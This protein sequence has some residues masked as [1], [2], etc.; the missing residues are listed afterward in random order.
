MSVTHPNSYA[1]FTTTSDNIS[2]I[3]AAQSFMLENFE[4]VVCLMTSWAEDAGQD[5]YGNET[6]EKLHYELKSLINLFEKTDKISE[7][8]VVILAECPKGG[9]QQR[10]INLLDTEKLLADIGVLDRLLAAD[11][12]DDTDYDALIAKHALFRD[13]PFPDRWFV[14]DERVPNL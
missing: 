1:L 6:E 4:G 3:L 12:L 14:L 10:F 5:T 8:I 9:H 2:D 11:F 7:D 13:G